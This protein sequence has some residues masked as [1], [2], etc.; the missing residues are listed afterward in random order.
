MHTN[1]VYMSFAAE[2]KDRLALVLPQALADQDLIISFD[3]EAIRLVVHKDITDGAI[4]RL[5]STIKAQL[6]A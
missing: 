4:E 5:V 3:K 1:M 6:A 2:I